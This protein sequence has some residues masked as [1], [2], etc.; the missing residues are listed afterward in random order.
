MDQSSSFETDTHSN[1]A[2]MRPL[3][4]FQRMDRRDGWDHPSRTDFRVPCNDL[5]VIGR[6]ASQFLK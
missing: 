1:L 6:D 5:S 2:G 4:R 3:W